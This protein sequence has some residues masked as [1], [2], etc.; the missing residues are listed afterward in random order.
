M[1]LIPIRVEAHAA[2]RPM[3]GGT[4]S[5]GWSLVERRRDRAPQASTP[6]GQLPTT[7][8]WWTTH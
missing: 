2:S 1:E 6:N 7:A 8:T 5:I 3:R 4:G